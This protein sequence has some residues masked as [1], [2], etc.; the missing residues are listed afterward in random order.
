MIQTNQTDG[1]DPNIKISRGGLISLIIL[2]GPG[3]NWVEIS[4]NTTVEKFVKNQN[5]LGYDIVING[6]GILPSEYSKIKIK[7][8][9]RD[10]DQIFALCPKKDGKQKCSKER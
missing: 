4:P 9:F 6:V 3:E 2:P 8:G 7:G 1:K 10:G 5:L